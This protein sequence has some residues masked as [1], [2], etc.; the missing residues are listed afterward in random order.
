VNVWPGPKSIKTMPPL[1]Q[2]SVPLKFA[3]NSWPFPVGAGEAVWP[4]LLG[5]FPYFT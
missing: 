3:E 5:L 2:F 4:K 1:N